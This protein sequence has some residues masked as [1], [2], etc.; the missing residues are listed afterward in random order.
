MATARDRNA[1]FGPHFSNNLAP[2]VLHLSRAASREVFNIDDVATCGHGLLPW[3]D[4]NIPDMDGISTI[5]DSAILLGSRSPPEGII[6][7]TVAV[8]RIRNRKILKIQA[9][10]SG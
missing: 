9:I 7:G 2:I 10:D 3:M 6:T 5:D 4:Q 1:A 8:G